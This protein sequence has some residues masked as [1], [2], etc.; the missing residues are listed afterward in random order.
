[1]PMPRLMA[2]GPTWCLSRRG[3]LA[4]GAAG[5]LLPAAAHAAT[6]HERRALFGSWAEVVLPQGAAADPAPALQAVFVD[7]DALNQRWNAWKPGE[8]T[9]LNA[10]LRQGRSTAVAPD[11]RLLLQRATALEAASLGC[12]NAG[13]GA[14]VGAWGFHADVLTPGEAP[15][16]Q[17]LADLM[18]AQP[19]LG[20]LRWNGALVSSTGPTLQLD[21]G[22][23]AKGWAV[24]R[25]LDAL[26]ARGVGDALVNLGGNLACMGLG[27]ARRAWCVG[28][29]D[30]FGPG[31]MARLQ[32]AGREAVVTSGTYERRRRVGDGWISHVLQPRAG[33]PAQEL[34]SVTVVHGQADVADAAATALLAAG[35]DRWPE[36]ARRMD[37]AQVLVV[38][39][40]GTRKVTPALRRRLLPPA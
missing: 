13:L 8:L 28:L 12:F 25:A 11:L 26:R 39:A 38:H 35:A 30:P 5:V 3:A 2:E 6:V 31:L 19:G 22:G 36:V 32:T 20:Q 14:L 37:L 4:L 15:S 23:I 40:D 7:L 33:R 18:R 10:S 9:R 24:D 34:V 17:R 29:R 1:M 27:P 21:L 16:P